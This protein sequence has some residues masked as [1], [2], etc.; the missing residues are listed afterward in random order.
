MTCPDF[1]WFAPPCTV[2]SPL[3]QLNVDTPEKQEALQADRDYQEVTFL[4]LVKRGYQ[5]QQREGRHAA[6]EQPKNARSWATPTFVTIMDVFDSIFDQC[7]YG[8][9]LP[10]ENY[11]EQYVKKPTKLRCTDETMALDLA[12]TCQGGHWHLPI[13]GS[14]PGIGS[15]SAASGVYQ[16][17]LCYS[18]YLAIEQIFAY[19]GQDAIYVADDEA[20]IKEEFKLEKMEE[21]DEF[22]DLES[23]DEPPAAPSGVL[24]RLR[25]E[26]MQK[27]RRTI[28]RLHRNLGHPTK[29]EPIRL[30]QNKNASSALLTAARE[31]ECQLCELHHRPTGVPV[32]SMPRNSTFN[33]RVQADTL[34]IQVPGQKH[35]QPV[36]MISDSTTRLLAGRH[37]RGGESTEEFI[38]QLERAWVRH[39]GPM[40]V[41]QVDEHRAWSSDRM[42]EWCC[43]Q[44]IL[45]Q[46][47]P[48]QAHTR[49]AVLERR[50]QVTRRVATLFLQG[51]PSLAEDP[52]GLVTALNYVIP[53][54]NRSPNVCGFSPIQWTWGYT[55]HVPGLLMEEQTGSNPAHLDP[56]AQFMEKLRLQQEAAKATAQA[57]GDQRLR[58]ALLRKF[59]GQQTLLSAGDLCYYWRDAPAGSVAKLRWRGPATV[60]MRE[61]GPTGPNNDIYWLDHGTVLLIAAP[62]HVKPAQVAQD[63]TEKQKDP[64]DVAKEAL[65][66]IRNR[67]VT[68]YIDL[69]KTNKRRRDEIA[70]DEE[71]GEDDRDMGRFPVQEL[72]PNHWQ[73]SDD[74]RLWT[75]VHN[76]PRRKF[77]VPT[78]S[79]NV[80]VHLFKPERTTDIRR[81]VPHPEHLRIR[82]EWKVPQGNRELHYTWTGTTTFVVDAGRLSEPY[83]PGTPMDSEQDDDGEEPEGPMDDDELPDEAPMG[84]PPPPTTTTSSSAKPSSS[85]HLHPATTTP[86]DAELPEQSPTAQ[87][88]MEPEPLEEP[89]VPPSLTTSYLPIPEG[90]KPFFVPENK[91]SFAQQRARVARQE[92]LLIRR[93]ESYVPA[94]A[95]PARETPY[96]QKPLN[97]DDKIEFTCEVDLLP[98]SHSPPGWNYENGYMVLGEIEDEWC[99]E[100]NYLTRMHY[101]AREKEFTPTEDNCPVPLRCL[102]RQ[103]ITKLA[104]GQVVRDKWTRGTPCRQLTGQTWT[105]YTR[106]KI[107][108]PHRK[109]AKNIFQDKSFGAETIYL[110][111]DKT[112][113]P[114]S[115]RTMSLSDR[116]AFKEAKQK[117][118][119]SFF[120]NDVWVFD[121]EANAR[122]DRILRAKFILNWKTN[123]DGSPRAKA[124]LICQ[125][126]EDPDALSGTL[127]TASPTLTRLSR[128]FVLSIASML[129]YYPFTA[130]ISTAFL[131]GKSY[132]PDSEREIWVKL[133]REVDDLLGLPARHGRVMKLI[134]PMYGL[135]DA[136]KA[137]FDEA[138]E[139]ILKMGNGAIVQHLLDSCLFLAFDGPI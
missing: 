7:E 118:L 90:Q 71:E 73:S 109:D 20:A 4:K 12:R 96:S 114:L 39:F 117:E 106:F 16:A 24:S 9:T 132:D 68:H 69:G 45:L 31:H 127:T 8:V 21:M 57:D 23:P 88:V 130:D 79:E 108:T 82:D 46:I 119:A 33:H 91:E 49:L 32:S 107:Q 122:P 137:W 134:K 3:Q 17:E 43:E 66:G 47:S 121:E 70:S 64:L 38:K 30:L 1:V 53:Q 80:P 29:K 84:P 135:V 44:G 25:D 105:G 115:E 36:L 126:L 65:Q 77:Y 94:T 139:R 136:P 104:K 93:P 123:V 27:A 34:W 92:T 87:S 75:R 103:R 81:E 112:N 97:D 116:L 35:Q 133:P 51:N 42:R 86:A 50:H 22:P 102:A 26:D 54:I 62:E 5:K 78:L 101:V 2:W 52:D 56:S 63:V 128:N 15:R 74:G 85:P 67:G 55:P 61:P 10:D 110:Q 60:I 113:A 72:P 129:G 14:S 138:V 98:N 13:E 58:R 89:Q 19:K 59:M 124:R 100:G 40:Q 131:Q 111:E 125:G 95:Q 18:F 11:E 120:Q 28:T 48:G 83:E 99:I 37:L 41:L 76:I 6:V